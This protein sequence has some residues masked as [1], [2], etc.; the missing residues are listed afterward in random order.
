MRLAASLA[1]GSLLG[2]ILTACGGNP[3]PQ[4][5]PAPRSSTSPS[6][7][8]SPTPTPPVM[9]AA[10]RK[11]TKQGAIAFVKYYVDA[12]NHATFTGHTEPAHSLDAGKCGSCDRMLKM[13]ETIYGADGSV[14][15]GAWR[16]EIV[17]AIRQRGRPGWTID[18]KIT[19]GPQQVVPR[20]GS[21]AESFTGGGRLVTF[22]LSRSGA[23]WKV[24]E[25]TRAS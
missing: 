8:A 4:P 14:N 19:Y 5:M 16:P 22:L 7:S 13:I 15:G 17:G 12:L 23:T 18:A 21:K 3:E 1:A 25:W 11:K 24:T 10:A 20:A 2:L 6:G 9:P